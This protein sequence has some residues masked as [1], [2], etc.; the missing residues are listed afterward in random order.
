MLDKLLTSIQA[1]INERTTSPLMGSFVVSWILWNYKFL[2][3]LFSSA[4]VSRTF[5]MIHSIA[6]PNT[7]AILLKGFALPGLTAAAYIFLYPYP[8]KFVYEFSRRRQKD[9]NDIRRQID[10][11]TPLTLEESRKLRAD[12]FRSENEYIQQLDRKDAEIARLKAQIA[13]LRDEEPSLPVTNERED[14]RVELEPSQ[15]F[16]LRLVEALKGKAPEKALLQRSTQSQ[17]KTEFDL[18]ELVRLKL[19]TRNYR[20]SM[21]DYIY[22]FTHAGRSYL[23]KHSE[24]PHVE[25]PAKA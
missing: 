3:I 11:E 12:I 18:G 23:L 16:M 13:E 5:E 24:D 8:A 20:G 9:I 2:V 25:K 21:S 6:F 15:L 7:T 19:L 17:T 4:T 22:E 14:K 10:D 1:Q